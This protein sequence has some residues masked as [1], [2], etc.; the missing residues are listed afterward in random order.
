MIFENVYASWIF[1]HYPPQLGDSEW[2]AAP[3]E[4]VMFSAD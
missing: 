2:G 1:G 3:E 4:R